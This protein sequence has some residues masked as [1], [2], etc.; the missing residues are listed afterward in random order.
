M[1]QTVQLMDMVDRTM[2]ER[3][4]DI[5]TIS[6]LIIF[7][8]I[9]ATKNDK[10]TQKNAEYLLNKLLSTS[11]PWENLMIFDNKEKI[12]VN[13]NQEVNE[14]VFDN[15]IKTAYDSALSGVTYY[16]DVIKISEKLVVIFASPI[17]DRNIFGKPI[18]GVAM[19]FYSW[20]AMEETLN[21]KEDN[22]VYL[23][24]SK[25][26]HL[27]SNSELAS[28]TDVE[29][30][31]HPIIRK[32]I[33]EKVGIAQ[34]QGLHS[35]EE[36]LFIF[37][38][39][40]GYMQYA[41]NNWI[42]LMEVPVKQI[43]R[44]V[45]DIILPILL[46]YLI[47]CFLLLMTLFYFIRISIVTP[48]SMLT[49]I[50]KTIES[51]DLTARV[52]IKSRDELGDLGVAFNNMTNKVKNLY[53]SM[54]Q[55]VKERTESLD[56]NLRL[57]KEKN[58]VLDKNKSAMLNVL[59]DDKMLE[60]ALKDEKENVEKKIIERTMELSNTKARLDSSIENLPLGFLMV[61]IEEKLVVT[62]S[63]A[64]DIL[65]K[66]DGVSCFIQ[67]KS[68]LK[69]K[70]DLSKYIK[71]C[72]LDKKR[73]DFTDIEIKGKYYHFLLSPILTKEINESC[74][75]VVVLIQD[76]TE[77]KILERSKDEFFSIASHELRT[78]L[79]AIRGNT[80]MIL[81]YYGEAIKDPEL[82]AMVDDIHES[83]IRLINIVNDFLNVSRL[84]QSRMEFNIKEFDISEIINE[85]LKEYNVT[86]SQ[87]KISMDYEKETNPPPK[88][89]GDADKVRQVLINLVGNSIKF[90]EQGGVKISTEVMN[91]FVKVL[92]S[93]TGRG[94]PLKQQ[95]LLFH[96]FQ[97]A[98]A[99]LFTRDTAGGSGLGLYISRMMLEG[100]GGEIKLEKSEE[101]K[102]STFSFTIPISLK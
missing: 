100:M 95:S 13:S 93:D 14:V 39:Q 58:E 62:N 76:I 44:L 67:L 4:Q 73:L 59:E 45:F 51:G 47:I 52:S 64:K 26:L 102:G 49:D 2:Y 98:G 72:G 89:V 92:V 96:K 55:K 7:Q 81:E 18:T 36:S 68:L 28:P 65:E 48:I 32:A 24:N 60:Q 101:G 5:E 25:G 43:D 78:P 85:T 80:S 33:K 57:L 86:G 70:I 90:T 87:N 77:A 3:F 91:K 31:E 94:I 63:L 66:K 50:A 54:E 41:G 30:L 23:L 82:K 79:T 46:T 9:L 6:N 74:I 12:I 17:V 56:G 37:S 53:D 75:G 27:D 20:P 69:D 19:G 16:S 40:K 1:D 38:L 42:M 99:S 10:V 21:K 34:F 71:N 97:Q 8:D 29:H 84:E 22:G 83:S 15:N 35:N 88:V 11:G 61:D